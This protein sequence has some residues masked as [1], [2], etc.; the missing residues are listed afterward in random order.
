MVGRIAALEPVG[1]DVRL[2]VSVGSL[3]FDAVQLGESIAVN[4]VCLYRDD[5]DNLFV[6]LV[7]EE[8]KGEQWLVGN[9]STLLNASNQPEV[10]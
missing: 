5:A 1:G 10:H 7:G 6:F 9:G 3:P 4:G 8:G 2:T